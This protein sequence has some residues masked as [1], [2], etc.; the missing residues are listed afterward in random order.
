MTVPGPC[1]VLD[2]LQKM[3]LSILGEHV[4][5]S[6]AES[7][8]FQVIFFHFWAEP[9]SVLITWAGRSG[10]EFSPQSGWW[11]ADSASWAEPW[12]GG[13][14]GVP[15]ELRLSAAERPDADTVPWRGRQRQR[16]QILSPRGPV[17]IF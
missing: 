6:G 14:A 12:V 9:W 10:S 11:S 15:K 5:D 2:E 16:T 13:Y 7:G 3:S 17:V 8:P 4:A 1:G